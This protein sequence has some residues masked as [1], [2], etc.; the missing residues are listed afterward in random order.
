MVCYFYPAGNIKGEFASNVSKIEVKP[1]QFNLPAQQD[2]QTVHAIQ[3]VQ[4]GQAARTIDSPNSSF[5]QTSNNDFSF[6][7]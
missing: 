3:A 1:T 4:A 5:N 7:D 6:S 2:R